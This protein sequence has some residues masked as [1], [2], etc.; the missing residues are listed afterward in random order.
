[1][2][3]EAR[4]VLLLCSQQNRR[5]HQR[6]LLMMRFWRDVKKMN[7]ELNTMAVPK[8]RR[9]N[10]L[11]PL[12]SKLE[13]AIISRYTTFSHNACC[14]ILRLQLECSSISGL[15][16]TIEHYRD[17]DTSNLNSI[18]NQLRV[19]RQ[20]NKKYCFICWYNFPPVGL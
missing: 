4:R 10:T 19:F 2:N 15:C 5:Q 13:A 12:H 1:M 20:I 8:H 17:I 18:F 6:T 11:R 3:D 16:E 14:E 9:F 7:N